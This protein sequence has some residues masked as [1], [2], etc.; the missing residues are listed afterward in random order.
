MIKIKMHSALYGIT[1]RALEGR[2]F[3]SFSNWIFRTVQFADY[4]DLDMY[5]YFRNL[6]LYSA[7]YPMVSKRSVM[8]A[9]DILAAQSPRIKYLVDNVQPPVV[10][11][12]N[13]TLRYS[14][15][16]HQSGILDNYEH[17]Y[18]GF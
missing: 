3:A 4:L 8:K 6:L 12:S 11:Y 7:D 1:R 14:P 17:S 10:H 13:H 15:M 9:I 16:E 5:M 18:K 2:K